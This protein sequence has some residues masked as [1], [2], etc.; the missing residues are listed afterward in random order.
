MPSLLATLRLLLPF[1][2]LER[3]FCWR[4]AGLARSHR[5]LS[6][7]S[8]LLTSWWADTDSARRWLQSEA[9]QRFDARAGALGAQ[10]W[11]ELHQTAAPAEPG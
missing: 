10:R 6:R 2:R 8:L 5:W 4:A 9:F 7:R 3:R 11:S 1:R